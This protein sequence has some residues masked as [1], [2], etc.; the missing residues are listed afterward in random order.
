MYKV[1]V[2][3]V[4]RAG[5]PITERFVNIVSDV[6]MTP[7]MIEAEIEKQWGEWEKYAPELLTGLQVWS[8]Y[9][10]VSE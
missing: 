3:S 10:R 1:K 9:K 2:Q 4:L 8:A 5:E 6:P 7:A